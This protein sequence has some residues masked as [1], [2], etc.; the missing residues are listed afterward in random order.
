MASLGTHVPVE[1]PV[2]DEP[3]RLPIA[4]V[5]TSRSALTVQIDTA[6]LHAHVAEHRAPAGAA[7]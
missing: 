5:S 6:P 4:D 3:V 2:C 7:T 1:C